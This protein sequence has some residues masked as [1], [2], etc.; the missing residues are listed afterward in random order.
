MGRPYPQSPKDIKN[1]KLP[2]HSAIFSD[3]QL[4]FPWI[5]VGVRLMSDIFSGTVSW[6]LR[7]KSEN[8]VSQ[9]K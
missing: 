5:F 1:F 9:K 3:S 7:E 2:V 6:E 4:E 8:L